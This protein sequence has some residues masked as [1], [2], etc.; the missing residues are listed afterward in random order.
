MLVARSPLFSHGRRVS[1]A[2]PSRVEHGHGGLERRPFPPHAFLGRT[3]E[4][5]RDL[6]RIFPGKHARLE[7]E[8]IAPLRHLCGPKT[9]FWCALFHGICLDLLLLDFSF[10]YSLY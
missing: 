3:L 5:L 4:R 10:P 8:R 2:R 7:I 6:S 1:E 9:G